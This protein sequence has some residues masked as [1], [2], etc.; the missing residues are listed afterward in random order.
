VRVQDGVF[1]ARIDGGRAN[2]RH[3]A[4]DGTVIRSETIQPGDR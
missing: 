2:V 4:A 3:I 1:A